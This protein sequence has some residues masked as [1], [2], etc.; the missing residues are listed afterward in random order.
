MI[1]IIDIFNIIFQIKLI[2][3]IELGAQNLID[4][5][6]NFV[7][8]YLIISLFFIGFLCFPLFSIFFLFA[9]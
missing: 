1:I 7:T 5:W 6:L 3:A 8:I 2:I 9:F 4:H